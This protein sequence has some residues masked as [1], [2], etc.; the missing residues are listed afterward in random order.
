MK[1]LLHF[2]W[3]VLLMLAISTESPAQTPRNLVAGTGALTNSLAI[4][5]GS[6][7]IN[8]ISGNTL[9]PTSSKQ[10]VLYLAFTG[11]AGADINGMVL[12]KTNRNNFEIVDVTP[13]TL[14]GSQSPIIDFGAA[15]CPSPVNTSHPC[16]VRLDPVNIKLSPLHDY[17]FV[18]FFPNDVTNTDLDSSASLNSSTTVHGGKDSNDDTLF[19]KGDILPSGIINKGFALFLVGVMDN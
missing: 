9:F 19:K 18:M 8:L 7:A 6:S 14:G 2:G 4:W 11:G 16:F 3:A 17:Y 12:Y 15:G 10:T 5:A 13:V 1:C